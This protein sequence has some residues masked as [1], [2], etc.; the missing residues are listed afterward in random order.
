MNVLLAAA[1]FVAGNAGIEGRV[2]DI[3]ILGV[4]MILYNAQGFTETGGLK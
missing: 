3:E 1:V 4:Q 2:H